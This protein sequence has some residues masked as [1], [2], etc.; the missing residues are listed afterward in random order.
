MSEE[1][2]QQDKVFDLATYRKHV[3]STTTYDAADKDAIVEDQNLVLSDFLAKVQ[4]F[5][6]KYGQILYVGISQQMHLNL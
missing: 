6:R 4:P 2:K 1:T 3:I 5:E